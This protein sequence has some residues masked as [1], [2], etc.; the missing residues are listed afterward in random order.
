MRVIAPLSGPI[1][2]L[3]EIPD[4]V[5]AQGLVGDGLAIDPI[6][7]V[8][9]SPCNGRVVFLHPAHHAIT[10]E[11]DEGLQI[12]M[13]IG[14]ETVQLKGRG[15][16]PFV[17]QGD[18][19]NIQDKLIEFDI[20][21]V[22]THARSLI[23]PIVVVE[24]D[25]VQIEFPNLEQVK[26]SIDELFSVKF[27]SAAADMN[28]DKEQDH[29]SEKLRVLDPTGLHARPASLIANLAKRFQQTVIEMEYQGRRANAK[30]VV[31]IM[32]LEIP[33]QGEVYFVASGLKAQLALQHLTEQFNKQMELALA[34]YGRTKENLPLVQFDSMP[35][36]QEENVLVGV[37]ASPGLAVGQVLQLVHESFPV[38][39]KGEG[40]QQEE[41][42]FEQAIL[43]AKE[44]LESLRQQV[45]RQANSNKSA[46]FSAHKELIEDPDLVSDVFAKMKKGH[47]A[48]YSWKAV[49]D[50]HAGRLEK[51]SNQL[52]A[53]RANDLRDVG[54]RVLRLLLGFK[55][56]QIQASNNTILIAEQLTPSD[57][58]SLDRSKI[59]GFC[60][61]SGGT[62][63]HVAILARS[64]GIPAIAGIDPKVLE[65]VDG[66]QVILNGS[67]GQLRLQP[68]AVQV[69]EALQHQE[70]QSRQRQKDLDKS[71]QPAF[72]IDN[73]HIEV[74][75][76]IGGVSDAAEAVR[77]GCEG[78]GLLRSEFLFLKR[79]SA[80]TENE[81]WQIYQEIADILGE[82][83]L[84]IR[85]LDV[86]GDKPLAY[87]PFPHEV[88]PFL[89]E[90]GLRFCLAHPEIFQTQ[91]RAILR[92]QTR[93][94]LRVM[95]P[96]VA[97]IEEVR[98][99]KKILEEERVKLNVPP[100]KVGVMVE[101]PSAAL[102]AD[103]LA[104]EVDFFSIGTNDLTQYSLAMDRG[105]PKLASSM[106]GLHP[107]VLKLIEMT[108]QGAH[109]FGR[110]VG[111]CGG[112]ASDHQAIPVLIGL[113]VDELSV[114]VQDIPAVKAQIRTQTYVQCKNLSAETLTMDGATTVRKFM[115]D[116]L[117]F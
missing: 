30:S 47:S 62:V 60:T 53:A 74:A 94:E 52:L 92:V 35:Q 89:G 99:A 39:E 105:H 43:A 67:K 111:V 5:F 42:K 22:A 41:K 25:G 9:R 82:R 77:L 45:Q 104:E 69:Q 51:L 88:N 14:L 38:P 64:L 112:I 114:S 18:R 26:A 78:V 61:T 15:F 40:I 109:K 36:V 81:Q 10:I 34:N 48:A 58:A 103:K 101:V 90:K 8:L 95:F 27:K 79:E 56:R 71:L 116:K 87:L 4:P 73:Q 84:T 117:D 110:W 6:E 85:T 107:G 12:L 50:T 108:V 33:G 100:I 17:K 76:N 31:G 68:T 93:G 28:T 23:S 80:P 86:G 19:V 11:T 24:P 2:S 7:G 57:T 113:G 44:Q 21:W 98:N 13:H 63:S 16:Y 37:S 70:E 66:T 1:V 72:T 102:I 96:M 55:T 83:P 59:L 46:I 49:V 97:N 115:E 75:A 65:I 29:I 32:S 20:D 3:K 91:L 54:D 106:D